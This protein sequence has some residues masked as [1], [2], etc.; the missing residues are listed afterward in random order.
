MVDF[1]KILSKQAETIEKPKP[2]PIGTFIFL[3]TALPE[4][5]GIG[6]KETPAAV[7]SLQ[8]VAPTDDVDMDQLKAYGE[9]K[10]KKQRFVMYLS[11]NAEYRTLEEL[12]NSFGIDKTGK[13]LG[14]MFNETVNK[15]VYG[16]IKHRPS[17]D[18]TEIYAEIE[19]L[20]RVD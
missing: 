14:Q 7:F 8:L 16:T 17:D 13:T 3:N 18:G 2:L 15:Q 20:A 6:K 12:E 9:W 4:F 5:T 10:G 1:S 11:E 19:K